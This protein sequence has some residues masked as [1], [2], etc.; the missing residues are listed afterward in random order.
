MASLGIAP[1]DLKRGNKG[2]QEPDKR[3]CR[4]CQMWDVPSLVPDDETVARVRG[5]A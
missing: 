1:A 4:V 5:R 3:G 2:Q